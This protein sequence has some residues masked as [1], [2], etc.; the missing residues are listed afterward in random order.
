VISKRTQSR[1]NQV[2]FT[3]P[4]DSQVV[5]IFESILNPHLSKFESPDIA[6]LGTAVAKATL[7][8]YKGVIGSF[9]PTSEKFHY[10]F[11]IRDVAKV[12][13]GVL[14]SDPNHFEQLERADHD[15]RTIFLR[16]WC[17]ECLR[18]FADRFV[19][20]A[21]NDHDRFR[22]LVNTV[23]G[24]VFGV[25]WNTLHETLAKPE[26]G[27][28]FCSFLTEGDENPPYTWVP[29][30]GPLKV[31]LEDALEMY[32]MEPKLLSMDLVLFEDAMRHIA[33]IHRVIKQPRGNLMLVGIGGSGRQSLARL[34]TFIAEYRLFMIEITK[35]YRSIEFHDDLKALYT[36]AGCDNKKVTF[37][38]NETQ[39][40]EESFLEDLNNILSSGVV[41]NLFGKDEYGAIFDGVR[42]DAIKAGIDETPDQLFRFFID[43]VRA[44]LHIILCVSPV[45]E[46]LRVRCR[47]YPG[48]V[49]CTTIDWF[50]TWPEDALTSVALKFLSAVKL[51]EGDV[52]VNVALLFSHFHLSVINKSTQM[53]LELKRQNYV[54]PTH[55]LELT[56]G[57]KTLLDEKRSELGNAC[58]RLENGLAKL[59][60]AKEQV[61]GLVGIV[62]DKKVVVAAAEGDCQELLKVIVVEKQAA[63]AQKAQVE[64][65]SERIA[66]EAEACNAIAADAKADLDVAMPALEKVR[67]RDEVHVI[68]FFFI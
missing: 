31:R 1:F 32:N 64:A 60:D 52:R 38:F 29:D 63:D 9:L 10:L 3:F 56:Q 36:E 45:G 24:S 67:E 65:D 68:S 34:A 27:G 15:Q 5:R 51:P 44:N 23:L 59:E 6:P 14:Q 54:T 57:Y 66:K 33:R 55:Y 20:D 12:V 37:L 50:H 30:M 22:A 48:L 43:R 26:A 39:I 40:K 18:V 53:R 25:D 19:L 16:L 7:D 2:H 17:H 13:Q 11:N 61:T 41:P 62:E 49:N 21:A 28:V 42:K 47:M 58:A 46:A 4:A 8:V 35:N